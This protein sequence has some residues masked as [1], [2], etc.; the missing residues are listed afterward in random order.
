M[1]LQ[2]LTYLTA[3][4]FLELIIY[5]FIYFIYIKLYACLPR[6]LVVFYISVYNFVQCSAA[7]RIC[8]DVAKRLCLRLRQLPVCVC[9]GVCMY[10]L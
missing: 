7:F 8:F 3:Y 5:Y 10:V 6:I 1:V 2:G 4:T 9:V